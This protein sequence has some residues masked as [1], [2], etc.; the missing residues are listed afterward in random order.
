EQGDRLDEEG[1]D[2]L[3]VVIG[4]ADRLRQLVQDLLAFSRVTTHGKSLAPTDAQACLEVAT[5][6]LEI[7]IKESGARITHDSLPVVLAEESQLTQL[8]QNLVGNAI[9]YRGDNSPV[10]HIGVR[11]D[12]GVYEFFV[13]DNGIGIAPQF[14]KRVFKVF[15]RLHN[16]RDYDGT[17][18]GLAI[19]KRIV[20]RFGGQIR[21][22][23]ELGSG[24]TFYFTVN[25]STHTSPTR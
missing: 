20:E 19:C 7:A 5:D 15:Q 16:R 21:I 1:R 25:K 6:N 14:Q 23:S 11:E 22:E 4:A 13:S 2:Y 24:C 8:F 12:S 17:G 3:R 9:K 10:V 18:I